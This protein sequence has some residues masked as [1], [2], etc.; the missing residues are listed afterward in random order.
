[1]IGETFH[2]VS[3]VVSLTLMLGV[4]VLFY[5]SGLNR[6][7]MWTI[8]VTPLASIIGSGFL[9]VAPLLYQNFGGYHLAAIA[10]LN[11]VALAVG[12]VMRTNIQLFEPI[13]GNGNK[14]A[15]TLILFERASKLVLGL[16]FTIS[17]AF[18]LSLLSSFALEALGVR[19]M[20]SIRI[21]TTVLLVFIGFY[22]YSR[23]LHGMEGLEKVAVNV[24]LSIIAGLLLA[25][26]LGAAYV[27]VN[28]GGAA[29]AL[30]H[31]LN[32]E[33]LQVL[34]GML[35]VVQGFETARY[36][37]RDYSPGE[38]S[39]GQLI[40]QLIAAGVYVL[41]V[42]L[43][44]PL[45]LD[46]SQAPD[47]TAIISIVGRAAFGL[48]TA[49]SLAAIF[50]QFGAAVADTVGTGGIIEEE[51]R[52]RIPRRL[53]Y[54]IITSLAAVLLWSRDVFS[55]LTLA[56]RAFALFYC[57]QA[58][59]AFALAIETPG[60]PFRRVRIILFPVVAVVMMLIFLYALP[61]H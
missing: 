14:H 40:A 10:L 59:I 45:A 57:L 49:L 43:A 17:V 2:V 36:L 54:L 51:T 18:Y 11:I 37:G 5:A 38:R 3:G 12:W 15:V 44:A 16:S 23:G 25:L 27:S 1:V 48:A 53:G 6:S 35:L 19:S 29:P 50:S 24:K 47:E 26:G 28:G 41:F 34:G 32:L 8:V 31:R 4:L 22:G 20:L 21:M 7:R 58:I 39:R 13:L 30:D 60:I 33:S 52:G 46:L 9:V 56:S 55:V 61:A 42:P